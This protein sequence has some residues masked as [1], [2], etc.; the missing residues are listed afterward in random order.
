[1]E[2]QSQKTMVPR[3][4]RPPAISFHESLGHITMLDCD[5]AELACF[6]H[7][8]MCMEVMKP[9]YHQLG[10]GLVSSL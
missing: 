2:T 10:L 8:R 6:R 7:V 5:T 9:P 3:L 1:M 4:L